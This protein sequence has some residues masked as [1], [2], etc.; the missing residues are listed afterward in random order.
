MFFT[1]EEIPYEFLDDELDDELDKDLYESEDEFLD[2]VEKILL[3]EI[4][5]V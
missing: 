2:S 1:P 5:N 4:L 3:H